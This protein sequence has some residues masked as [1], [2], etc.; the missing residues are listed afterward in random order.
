MADALRDLSGPV[1]DRTLVL[2]AVRDLS[3]RFTAIGLHLRR[4]HPFPTFLQMRNDMLIEEVTML[5][6]PPPANFHRQ[7]LHAFPTVPD[8]VFAG[9][10]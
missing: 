1:F 10:P 4:S 2:N 8:T 6:T 9:V 3:K 5:K 7:R